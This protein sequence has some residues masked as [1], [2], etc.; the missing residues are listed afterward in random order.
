[1][2]KSE[3]GRRREDNQVKNRNASSARLALSNSTL[4]PEPS[5][6]FGAADPQRSDSAPPPGPGDWGR[7]RDVGQATSP[8]SSPPPSGFS[9]THRPRPLPP[10]F[11]HCPS[12][13]RRE[14]VSRPDRGPVCISAWGSL[15][16]G[17]LAASSAVA[18]AT[19]SAISGPSWR[20]VLPARASLAFR[21]GS[22]RR[23]WRREATTGERR[24]Q[25]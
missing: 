22:T 6:G 19:E 14:R 21:V 24:E 23:W 15:A 16:A 3:R 7:G 12:A 2:R 20:P 11:S 8:R 4:G 5:Q 13:G 17:S 10:S 25:R 9:L 1:M 18:E